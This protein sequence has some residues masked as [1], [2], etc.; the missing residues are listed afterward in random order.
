MFPNHKQAIYNVN[1]MLV[2]EPTPLGYYI[3]KLPSN[4]SYNSTTATT[5]TT[6]ELTFTVISSSGGW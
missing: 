2:P 6:I 1:T 3:K 5:T 4:Y